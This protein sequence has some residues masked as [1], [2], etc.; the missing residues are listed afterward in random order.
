MEPI[1]AESKVSLRQRVNTYIGCCPL[2]VVFEDGNEGVFGRGSGAL[3]VRLSVIKG[4]KAKQ[5]LIEIGNFCESAQ[6]TIQIGGEHPNSRIF[7]NSLSSVQLVRSFLVDHGIT[8][9]QATHSHPTRIG[10]GV[11]LSKNCLVNVGATIGLGAVIGSGSVVT[12]T[13][14]PDWSVA[15]GSPANKVKERISP[16]AQ[17]IALALEWWNWDIEFFVRHVHLLFDA[18]KH[19]KQLIAAR[20]MADNRYRLVVKMEGEAESLS[21]S[22]LG[23]DDEDRFVPIKE[24]SQ[25][26]QT[27]FGQMNS[28]EDSVLTW[29][30]NP[31][32]LL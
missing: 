13:A 4:Q 26:F 28:P 7:N 8:Q 3:L 18:E 32:H 19:Y 16:A 29:M 2:R 9:F 1:R 23:I 27:Y 12:R 21:L 15:V 6:C 11:I 24:T 5:P 20:V 22:I 17:E 31:F 14:I 25:A 30:P 10:H